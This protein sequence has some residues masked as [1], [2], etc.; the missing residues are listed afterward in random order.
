M[1]R[2]VL[3]LLIPLSLVAADGDSS[4]SWLR[5]MEGRPYADTAKIVEVRGDRADPF[6][7]E[8]IVLLN[9]SSARGGVREITI[10]GGKIASE[11]TP[12]RGQSETIGLLPMERGKLSFGADGVF[13]LVQQE[14]VRS[15]VGFHWLDYVLRG[16]PGSKV[17]V[18]QVRL[19]DHMGASIGSMAVSAQD[20]TIV[21][22]LQVESVARPESPGTSVGKLVDGVG[23]S[24]GNVARKTKDSTL[25]FIGTLEK[26]FLGERTIGP[27]EGDE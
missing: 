8:W 10:A 19:Y 7:R 14:A 1:L 21:R 3:V 18:W 4:F 27:K 16:D 23:G 11:R 9:D 26:E 25:R 20:G 12:L 13:R 15:K 6:P 24:V 2:M 22:A 17:P 5:A